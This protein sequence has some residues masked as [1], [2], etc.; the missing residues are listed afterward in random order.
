MIEAY[1]RGAVGV[2]PGAVWDELY[3]EIHD[4]H[5]S[6]D[7]DRAAELHTELLGALNTFQGVNS[8]KYLLAE[9]GVIETPHCRAPTSGLGDDVSRELLLDAHGRMMELIDSL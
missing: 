1:D 3:V 9:R 5:R 7:R 6:G 8:S 2:M 4:C